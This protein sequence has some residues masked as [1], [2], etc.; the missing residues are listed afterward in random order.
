LNRRPAS[1][2]L[3][4]VG[5][6]LAR[7]RSAWTEGPA[8]G[9]KSLT[10]FRFS[11]TVNG[12]PSTAGVPHLAAPAAIRPTV[13]GSLAAFAHSASL[14]YLQSTL[15]V[16]PSWPNRHWRRDAPSAPRT[17]PGCWTSTEEQ[18]QDRTVSKGAFGSSEY[19]WRTYS[20]DSAAGAGRCS[21]PRKMPSMIP[22]AR[23]STGLRALWLTV[24]GRAAARA[25]DPPAVL[26]TIV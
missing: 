3:L 13:Y 16:S 11:T 6:R 10:R 24:L 19:S 8:Q 23:R 20:E 17:S 21:T 9:C 14:R 22:C 2:H 1:L 7:V 12:L 4:K 5:H 15:A 26:G 18:Q 25:P